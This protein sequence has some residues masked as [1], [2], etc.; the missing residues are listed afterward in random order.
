MASWHPNGTCSKSSLSPE[1]HQI[2]TFCRVLVVDCD[3]LLPFV[4]CGFVAQ[5]RQFEATSKVG[6]SFV[7]I[8]YWR[9]IKRRHELG[10]IEQKTKSHLLPSVSELMQRYKP[11]CLE[12]LT[13]YGSN[14][15]DRTKGCCKRWCRLT[16]TGTFGLQSALNVV[17]MS[18][19]SMDR[20]PG[21]L[22]LHPLVMGRRPSAHK[23][24]RSLFVNG[25]VV[26]FLGLGTKQHTMQVTSLFELCFASPLTSQSMF[27]SNMV[28]SL[29]GE[30]RWL[31][32]LA[33]PGGYICWL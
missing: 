2:C 1:I 23:C 9:R 14:F 31:A 10:R 5:Q 6:N 8:L 29:E 25:W 30:G 26:S 13:N 24:S 4:F 32:R 3:G 18:P 33:G 11:R 20:L 22:W 17:R 15:P 19:S 7:H 27:N 12:C 16:L 28:S 21:L